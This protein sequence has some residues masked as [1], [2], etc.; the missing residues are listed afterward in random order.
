MTVEKAIKIKLE[1]DER[2]VLTKAYAII[3]DILENVVNNNADTIFIPNEVKIDINLLRNT[4]YTLDKLSDYLVPW[5][6]E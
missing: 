5:S 4:K 6:V 2:V 1:E 3:G